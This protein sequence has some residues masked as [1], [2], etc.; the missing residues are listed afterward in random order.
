MNQQFTILENVA[1][2]EVLE[3][4][5]AL[6]QSVKSLQKANS[7]NTRKLTELDAKLSRIVRILERREAVRNSG[8]F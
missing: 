5:E 1:D 4:L 3:K 8:G 2:K 7:I 6:D